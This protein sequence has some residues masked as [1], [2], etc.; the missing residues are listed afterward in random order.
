MI[1][2]E[3][4]QKISKLKYSV[5]KERTLDE[6]HW[7]T[8]CDDCQDKLKIKKIIHCNYP[9]CKETYEYEPYFYKMMGFDPP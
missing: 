3:I 8:P 6:E 4:C 1:V 2:C 5:Y 7:S 9:G